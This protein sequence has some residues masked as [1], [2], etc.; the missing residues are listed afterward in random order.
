MRRDQRD[1]RRGV[2]GIA[3]TI[4]AALA[5]LVWASHPTPALTAG[6]QDAVRQLIAGVTAALEDPALQGPAQ[7]A[8]RQ[9]RIARVIHDAF[10]YQ[11]MA[12]HSLGAQWAALTPAE[13]EEFTRLFADLFERSYRVLVVRFLGER[14]TT[15]VGES[16]DGQWALVRTRLISEKDGEMPVEYRLSA[17]GGRWTLVDIVVDGV[18]LAANYRVQFTKIIRT[19]SYQT[20]LQRMRKRVE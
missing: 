6:P 13:R 5:G 16:S 8:E 4:V 12:R 15:Y 17:V 3:L 19:S 20:L 9:H 1:P 18:S 14:T 2:P 11:D 7:K 10:D